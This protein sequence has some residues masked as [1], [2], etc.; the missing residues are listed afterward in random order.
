MHSAK[1]LFLQNRHVKMMAITDEL[2]ETT[3]AVCQM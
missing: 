3:A 1:N 2:L